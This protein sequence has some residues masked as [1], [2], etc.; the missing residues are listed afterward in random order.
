M[1]KDIFGNWKVEVND[2]I[3]GDDKGLFLTQSG[4]N[5]LSQHL[6][7][8]NLT[9]QLIKDYKIINNNLSE[10]KKEFSKIDD[11]RNELVKLKDSVVKELGELKSLKN[12]KAEFVKKEIEI[13]NN[14]FSNLKKEYEQNLKQIN[15]KS[16]TS[17]KELLNLQQELINKLNSEYL[18]KL[19]R[20][21]KVEDIDTLKIIEK[22]YSRSEGKLKIKD[23]QDLIKDIDEIIPKLNLP[24]KIKFKILQTKGKTEYGN[25]EKDEYILSDLPKHLEFI[26]N[27]LKAGLDL[28]NINTSIS[29]K[30]EKS[31]KDKEN[32]EDYI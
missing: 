16:E 23:A 29:T 25:K 21:I 11:L 7:P 26:I 22:L 31:K 10:L 5:V 9:E 14:N 24:A 2:L 27:S 3:G 28:E 18:K 32:S 19:D 12:K 6:T 8:I 13:I 17:K 15:E 20:Q 30:Q 1:K 4:Y